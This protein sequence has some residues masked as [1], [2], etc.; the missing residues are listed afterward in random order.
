M[1]FDFEYFSSANIV[2]YLQ[3]FPLLE[4]VGLAYDIKESKRPLYGYSSRFFDAV[5]RGQVIAVGQ[6][7]VNYVH[8]DYLFRAVELARNGQGTGLVDITSTKEII[9]PADQNEVFKAINEE[10]VE[11]SQ[12]L[13]E[14]KVQQYWNETPDKAAE[15]EVWDTYNMLDHYGGFNIKAAFG[16]QDSSQ[17]NGQT[18]YLL[19]SVHFTGQAQQIEISPEVSIVAYSFLARNVHSLKNPRMVVKV[20]PPSP[21]DDKFAVESTESGR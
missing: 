21:A 4:A 11:A 14:S 16:E 7:L 1:T 10:G 13:I 5:A 8:Q 20:P 2:I 19:T 17:R 15:V 3:D 6:L 12:E 18:G 9:V